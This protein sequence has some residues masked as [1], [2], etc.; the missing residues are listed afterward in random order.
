MEVDAL[1]SMEASADFVAE[2][3]LSGSSS[4]I[5]SLSV[6]RFRRFDSGSERVSAGLTFFDS[7]CR[8]V[9]RFFFF[10]ARTESSTLAA[11]LS[12]SAD[13]RLAASWCSFV[14]TCCPV[15]GGSSSLFSS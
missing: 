4:D 2:S 7:G 11:S 1:A 9:F 3:S 10:C 14:S 5:G 6:A 8:F 15:R 12:S 13:F